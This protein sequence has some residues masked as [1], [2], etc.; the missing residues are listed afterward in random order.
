MAFLPAFEA[1]RSLSAAAHFD[2]SQFHHCLLATAD[3]ARTVE[4]TGENYVSDSYQRPVRWILT[5]HR[6]Q[7][8]DTIQ[9][10]VVISPFEAQELLPLIKDSKCVTSHIYAP[11]PNLACA[12]LDGL[13]LFT[14]GRPFIAGS[15]PRHFVVLLNLF[16]AQL[17]LSSFDEYVGVCNFLGVPWKPAGE[18]LSVG[19]D[20]FIAGSGRNGG[21]KDSPVKF[22]E[23]LLTKIRRNCE[24]IEKTHLGKILHGVILEQADF[25]V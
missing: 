6:A 15:V 21:F 16:A 25:D 24:T 8:S 3:F 9:H 14:V 2:V 22:L 13:N 1:L 10:M 5:S 17:Y 4:V 11:R 20:G 7:P 12:A 18:G 19:A 23:V